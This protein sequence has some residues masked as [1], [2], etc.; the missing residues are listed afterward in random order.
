MNDLSYAN[1]S[2]WLIVAVAIIGIAYAWLQ[3]FSDPPSD[4]PE[5]ELRRIFRNFNSNH[6][7]WRAGYETRRAWHHVGLGTAL[8]AQMGVLYTAVWIRKSFQHLD[9]LLAMHLDRQVADHFTYL[10]TQQNIQAAL[11]YATQMGQRLPHK[12]ATEILLLT[13]ELSKILLQRHLNDEELRKIAATFQLRFDANKQ[14]KE[15]QDD[16]NGRFFNE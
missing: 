1:L 13:G 7:P 6:S 12:E 10:I 4:D 9:L 5:E 16:R 15:W 2:F 11:N 14:L 8:S 3:W